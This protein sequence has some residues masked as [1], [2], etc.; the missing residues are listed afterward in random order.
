MPVT[1]GAALLPE[2]VPPQVLL[3]YSH[4]S[5]EHE[6]RVLALADRLRADGIDA[7]IDL[8]V[9]SPREGWPA[10]CDAQIRQS[11]FV[12]MICTET[13]LRR[14]NGDEEPHVG[15]G[16]LWEGRLMKQHLYNAGSVS[17][18]FVPVLLAKAWRS[19]FPRRSRVRLSIGS[20]RPRTTRRYCGY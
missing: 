12:L 20:R 2:P 3:S 13:Y 14:V 8:Y 6:D 10:W 17:R 18:K 11:D 16:V 15:R 4:E 7:M 5:T 1:E 19:M 9:P